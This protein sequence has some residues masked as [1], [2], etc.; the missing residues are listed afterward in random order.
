MS[1]S[2]S[3][4]ARVCFCACVTTFYDTL[5]LITTYQRSFGK[6]FS[7]EAISFFAFF[8][9]IVQYLTE[10]LPVL[11]LKFAGMSPIEIVEETRRLRKM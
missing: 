6:Q 8:R 11:N 1:V 9:S 3:V 10:Q 7:E 4:C 2:G 5:I